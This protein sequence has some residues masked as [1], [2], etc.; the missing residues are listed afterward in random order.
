MGPGFSRA[1][2]AVRR[3][4]LFAALRRPVPAGYGR[5]MRFVR[6]GLWA[7]LLSAAAAAAETIWRIDN[8]AQIGGC[9]VTVIGAPVVE[10]TVVGRALRFDGVKDG[11]FVPE[12]PFA[13]AGA[14][15]IELLFCPAGDGPAEQRF[16]HAQDQGQSRALIELRLDGKG[17]WWLDTFIT[18]QASGGGVTLIDPARVHPADRWYWVALRY[19]GT[20]MAHFVDGRKELERAAAFAPLGEGRVSLGVRQNRVHWFKGLIR[21][22]RYHRTAVPD[23]SLQRVR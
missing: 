2:V 5:E 17:G 22:V 16:W 14:Y 21:E 11:C 10:D 8:L 1:R 19:D 13:G 12:I 4:R 18:N 3:R 9:A 20:R 23:A 6:M 15:T 7:A